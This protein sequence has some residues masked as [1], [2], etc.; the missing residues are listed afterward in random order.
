MILCP[1][2]DYTTNRSDALKRHLRKHNGQMLRCQ[3]CDY[4]TAHASNLKT[5][6]RKHTGEVFSCQHCDFTT[7]Q[8]ENLKRHSR[9]KHPG[10][11]F[12]SIETSILAVEKTCLAV[13]TT[14][15][16]SK[17]GVCWPWNVVILFGH[18]KVFFLILENRAINYLYEHLFAFLE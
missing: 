18:V 10:E 8:S 2:C 17:Q 15:L 16:H 11:K 9:N 1:H 7:I 3:Y 14:S 13:E 12:Q 5:H 4:I 6:N